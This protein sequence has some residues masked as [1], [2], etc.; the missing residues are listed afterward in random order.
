LAKQVEELAEAVA[1]LDLAFRWVCSLGAV[2]RDAAFE[3]VRAPGALLLLLRARACVRFHAPLCIRV[4]P[5]WRAA[6]C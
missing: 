2:E 4:G 3:S 1:R 5:N 6:L